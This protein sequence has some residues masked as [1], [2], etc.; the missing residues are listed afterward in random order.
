LSTSP[1]SALIGQ[2]AR[3]REGFGGVEKG[4]FDRAVRR[5]ASG[6]D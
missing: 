6:N 2:I 4:E 1:P 5:L 3:R